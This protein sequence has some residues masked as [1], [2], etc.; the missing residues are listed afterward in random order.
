MHFQ[1]RQLTRATLL[2]LREH[3]LYVCQRDGRGHIALELEM[4]Y[5]EILPVRAERRRQVPQRQLMGLLFGAL[6]LATSLVPREVSGAAWLAE[7]WGWVFAGGVGL[8]V[9]FYYGLHNWWSQRVL[10]TARAQ[11]VLADTPAERAAFQDFTTALDRRAKTYLRREYGT[12]NPLGNIEPQLRRVAWLRELDVFSPAEAR[13]LTTR[14]TGQ[15]P[16][17]PLTS[18]GQDLDMPFVN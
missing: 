7:S 17:A 2:A 9:F 11:V 8:V 14:L 4:P 1:Q 12:V 16:N 10:H 13:A 3:G 15:V 6:W 5:E 18:L